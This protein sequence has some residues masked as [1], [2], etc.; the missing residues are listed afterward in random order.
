MND[1]RRPPGDPSEYTI[2]A[3]EAGRRLHRSPSTL[4]RWR[5][6]PQEDP[7][8]LYGLKKGGRRWYYREQDIR[9]HPTYG[10]S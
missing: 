10:G 3:P 1:E 8:H 7:E 2:S 6:L 4:D 5:R 9:A